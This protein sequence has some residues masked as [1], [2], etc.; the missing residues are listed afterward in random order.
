VN[1]KVSRSPAFFDPPNVRAAAQAASLKNRVTYRANILMHAREP[2][3]PVYEAQVILLPP[4]HFS[5]IRCVLSVVT[6]YVLESRV[7]WR[8][9]PAGAT[10]PAPQ[11][12]MEEY[13]PLGRRVE[14]ARMSRG[15][16]C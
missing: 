14:T 6:R 8:G 12:C 5:L 10:K 4:Q 15:G 3:Q 1:K 11:S 9:R 2:K 7:W 16:P 13:R